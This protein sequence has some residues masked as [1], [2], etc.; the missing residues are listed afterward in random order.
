MK[1]SDKT[2]KISKPYN[3]VVRN[4]KWFTDLSYKSI[5]NEVKL[6]KVFPV[7]HCGSFS[8]INRPE[9]EME[10][11]WTFI[12]DW[13]NEKMPEIKKEYNLR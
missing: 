7:F 2:C 9:P 3:E 10:A 6:A 11:D 8:N 5:D 13:I 1:I 12:N 4:E